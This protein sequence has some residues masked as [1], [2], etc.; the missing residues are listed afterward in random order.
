MDKTDR[1]NRRGS[2]CKIC[3]PDGQNGSRRI[4]DYHG[5]NM[6]VPIKLLH[7]LVKHKWSSSV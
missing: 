1:P 5:C 4:A 3:H 2:K 7:A 6:E